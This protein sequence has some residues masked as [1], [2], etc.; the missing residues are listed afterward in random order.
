MADAVDRGALERGQTGL[1]AG[2]AGGVGHLGVQFAKH[3]G[4]RVIGT[5]SSRNCD[6]VRVL[7]ADEYVELHERD[8]GEA[9]TALDVA[10]DTV[11]G[12]DC[13]GIP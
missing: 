6:F 8:V 12:F 1:I 13:I 4:A 5:G 9:V 7:G 2:A 3:T 11:G 10:Y